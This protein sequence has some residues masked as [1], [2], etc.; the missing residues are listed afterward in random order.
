MKHNSLLRNQV[1][2]NLTKEQLADPGIK[3]LLSAVADTY[4]SSEKH[5]ENFQKKI[6][7][8]EHANQKLTT[9]LIKADALKNAVIEQLKATTKLIKIDFEIEASNESFDLPEVIE[10]FNQKISKLQKGFLKQSRSLRYS[11]RLLSK[12]NSAVLMK[13]DEG[14]VQYTNQRFCE[15][16]AISAKADEMIGEIFLFESASHLFKNQSAFKSMVTKLLAAKEQVCDQVFEL[17]DGRILQLDYIPI[18]IDNVFKGHLW[19]VKDVTIR[20]TDERKMN[21]LI[22]L[23]KAILDGTDYSIVYTDIG[24]VIRTF[25]RGAENMLGY[26]SEDV[27]NKFTP[28]LFHKNF[29]TGPNKGDASIDTDLHFQSAS[30]L[31]DSE[32]GKTLALTQ[33]SIYIKNNGE[34]LNVVLTASAICNSNSE[35]IGYLYIA[36]DI[37]ESKKAQQAL[38]ISEE[39]YRNIVERST[40]IIYKS[41]REGFFIFVNSVAERVTGYKQ[42]ELLGKH[43]S[44]L[45]REE[46]KKEAIAFYSSQLL[47]M[48]RTTYYE[49]PILTKEGKEVWIGQ[50]VQLSEIGQNEI[51]FTS[52]AIDITPRKNYERTIQLQNEK[53]RNII[54]NMN[55]GLLEVDLQDRVQF[56]NQGF[57]TLSG[58][59]I[60]EIIGKDASDLFLSKQQAPIVREKNQLRSK[61]LSDMY[62][63]SVVTKKG[64]QRWW[65]VSGAPNYND[66]GQLI[67]SIGIHLD[68]TEKKSLE[69]ALEAAMVKTEESSR[70][71]AA[72]LA[73]M[74]HEIRTPLNGIIGMIRELSYESLPERQ[75]KY[76][77]NASIASQHLF[78]VLNNILDISKIEAG[79]LNLE[80]NHFRLSDTVKEVKFIMLSRAREKGLLLSLN[81]HEIKEFVYLGD[82]ARIRQMLLNL[83][84]NAIK[85]TSSGGVFVEC[86][87]KE[88]QEKQHTILISIEDTGIGMDENYQQDLFKKFSQEDTSTSRKYGGTGLGMAIT[89]EI[90]QLMGGSIEV[91][92]TKTVGTTIALL[93]DLPLGDIAKIKDEKSRFIMSDLSRL[94]ILLVEDN[95]FN[96]LVAR[97]TLGR[98]KCRVTEAEN[99]QEALELIAKNKF[100][101][102]LM[103]IQMPI[104]D[105]FET[106]RAIREKLKMSVPIIALTANAFKTELDQCLSAGMNDYVTKPF[107]EDKLIAVINKVLHLSPAPLKTQN[108]DFETASENLY[109]LDKLTAMAR[110]DSSYVQK[111]VGVFVNQT[112]QALDQLVTAQA[113][114][115]LAKMY[116]IAHKIKPSLSSMGID[117]LYQTIRDV[118][119]LAKNGEDSTL[120]QQQLKTLISTLNTVLHQLQHA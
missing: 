115:D 79:E 19:D 83:I 4:A 9:E 75:M 10:N 33:E 30:Q 114:G 72:F 35:V 118:E 86:L 31:F 55:L 64:E 32:F 108:K 58:Y 22:N 6:E 77:E 105:G 43:F 46:Y 42:K 50:S 8:I 109:S 104:M 49:F 61:G 65:M 37:N 73:N 97:N 111:M 62:E 78:S 60:D 45:I 76:V 67:G 12:L 47:E 110:N 25:N 74:S 26:K 11:T 21:E 18:F 85:F 81:L 20:K 113:K 106:T 107:E 89:R 17:I 23:Q 117:C 96:R 54:T 51:E 69:L 13:D 92:S 27:L 84:G 98:C 41:D 1:E 119:M 53:Y 120:L 29:A 39:R 68:I 70:A 16:F 93:I 88:R 24:G 112:Q 116:Q 94:R 34:Q 103:D 36:R 44:E 40:D 14:R 52:L 90:V 38:A 59:E 82:S 95:A 57:T 2:I 100:D 7:Q 101:L 66:N 5:I 56:A 87:I 99:G 102:I 3:R 63:I 91:K 48:K 80:K 15:T 71:K 28:A